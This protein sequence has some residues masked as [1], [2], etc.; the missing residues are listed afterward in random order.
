[1]LYRISVSLLL[2]VLSSTTFA[3]RYK[4]ELKFPVD[5]KLG[6]T[7]YIQHYVDLDPSNNKKEVGG[8]KLT[9]NSHGG[10]DIALPTYAEMNKG[11]DVL[12]ADKGK[13]IKVRNSEDDHDSR[14]YE[15]D[16]KKPCGN[17]VII[18]HRSNWQTQYCH[19]KKDSITVKPGQRLQRGD[20]IGQVGA[21]GH[22]DFPHLHF[23]VRRH[24]R[25][26]DPFTA[27]L[28]QTPL[29]YVNLGL[30]DMGMA[31]KPLKLNDVLKNAPDTGTFS[32]YD[33]AFV[34]WV[35]VFGVEAGDKQ[36]FVFYK[37]DG[38]MYHKPVTNDIPKS[39]R[40]WFAFAGFP[41]TESIRK[42]LQGTW[43]VR[44]EVKPFDE[45]NWRVLGEHKFKIESN[46]NYTELED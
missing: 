34:A 44:Y 43:R 3:A 13:V 14:D 40:E 2:I 1:M 29:N 32:A 16:S 36:Q 37:P 38:S 15:F 8:G 19:L 22:A 4:P 31:D 7:C 39:Y 20:I 21:S 42:N 27:N 24:G 11:V 6:K 26:V 35:R 45:E 46:N 23:A 5:C 17:G 28:W 41:I 10:T 30:I 9:T 33:N 18:Q 25:V 12:A